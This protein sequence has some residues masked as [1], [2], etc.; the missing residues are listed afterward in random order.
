MIPWLY[1]K[2]G[3]FL[4]D[5]VYAANDGIVTTFAVVAGVV[6]ASLDPLIILVLGF[7]NLFADGISMASG[8]YL[9][10]KSEKDL[11]SKERARNLRLLGEDK[12]K[13]K[14][15]IANFLRNKG[16]ANSDLSGLSELIAHNEKFALDFIMHEEAGLVEQE[17]ARPLKGALVTLAS[18]ML[19]GLVPL[20]PY[21][22]FAGSASAFLYASIFT[23]IALFSMGATR[24]LFTEKSWLASGLEM[25]FVGGFAAVVAYAIGFGVSSIV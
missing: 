10:T 13:Y 1:K 25:F 20:V 14:E 8:N 22:F 5:A 11:Y 23:G 18:F 19:A 3:E 6:G 9:G 2:I 4:K 15:R 16:Y 24:S 21:I 7:A 17:A 12:E